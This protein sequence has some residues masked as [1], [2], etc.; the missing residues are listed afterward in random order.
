MNNT[1]EKKMTKRAYFK[2]FKNKYPLTKDEAEFIDKQIALLNKKSSNKKN[3]MQNSPNNF[4]LYPDAV[5][6]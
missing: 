3:F 6:Q 5:F 1:S 2:Q 4:I